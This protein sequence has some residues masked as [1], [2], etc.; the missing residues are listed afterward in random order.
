[1]S[2][3]LRFFFLCFFL[4]SVLNAA[5]YELFTGPQGEIFPSTI[6]ASSN[7]KDDMFEPD[8]ETLGD[9]FGIIGIIIEAPANNT[10]IKLEMSGQKLFSQSVYEGVL[11]K[12]G[13]KYGVF[14]YL[15]YNVDFL[16][17]IRQPFSEVISA[18]VSLAGENLPEKSCKA[19]VRSINDCLLT[20]DEDGETIDTYWII[21]S[22]V[23]ENHP[24]I[25][26][27]LK[28]AL[29][30]KRVEQFAG[31]QG[32]EDDVKKEIKAIWDTLKARGIKYSSIVRPSMVDADDFSC[33]HIRLIGEALKNKQASC[34]EG[35][36]LFASILRKIDMDPFIVL[37]P[38]HAFIGVYL[39]EDHEDFICFET[40]MLADSSF[41][42][43]VETGM[44]EYEKHEKKLMNEFDDKN[45]KKKRVSDD[46]AEYGIVD[47]EEVRQ[48]GV[49]PIREPS[50]E[51][52]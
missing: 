28:E 21:G 1:M 2:F 16:S 32:D 11:P 25:E 13:V 29:A 23:N 35:S 38:G 20:Y 6:I 9:P 24:E 7:L 8:P 4:C 47:I 37:I 31:Y 50:A 39:D 3:C 48:L 36:V 12:K 51:K 18:K 45:S 30:K 33:M 42:E 5:D 15:K 41:D 44:E 22:Y 34:L 19:L 26:Y 43:A 49:L 27:I 14:P 17:S 52:R 40:T 10:K 46:Q